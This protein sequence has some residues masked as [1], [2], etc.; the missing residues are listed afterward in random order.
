M[1]RQSDLKQLCEVSKCLYDIVTPIL[2][3][4]IS[5]KADEAHLEKIDASPF[6]ITRHGPNNLL[7]HVRNVEFTSLF[8]TQLISR[9]IHDKP[10]YPQTGF[11]FLYD[12]VDEVEDEIISSAAR[13]T[14][15]TGN[16]EDKGDTESDFSVCDSERLKEGWE[17]NEDNKQ[18]V[19]DETD[20]E[21]ETD[22]ETYEGEDENESDYSRLTFAQLA[23]NLLPLLQG[24]KDDALRTF[25]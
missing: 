25:T 19:D 17:H 7:R 18:D 6:L 12:D 15:D 8:H 20:D 23:S 24:C 4:S 21:D 22:K 14:E 11:G 10:N 5:I 3:K 9:C 16:V 1:P 2:Y 13:V